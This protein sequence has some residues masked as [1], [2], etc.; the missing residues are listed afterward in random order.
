MQ[1]DALAGNQVVAYDRG[2]DGALTQ[3]G[4][5]R[6][7]RPGGRLT[8]AVVDFT[9]SQGALTADRAHDEL[10]AVNAGSDT[11]TV[12]G[13]DGDRLRSARSSHRAATSRSASPRTATASSCSTPATAAASRATGASAAGCSGAAWHRELNLPVTDE[14]APPSSRTRRARSRSRPTAAT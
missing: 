8:G 4:D 2:A 9:A 10:L 6:H 11:L 5:L 14:A 1:N 7:R 3:A 13:V 12:F